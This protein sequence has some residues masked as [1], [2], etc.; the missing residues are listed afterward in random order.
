MTILLPNRSLTP[1]R[2]GFK[3]GAERVFEEGTVGVPDLYEAPLDQFGEDAVERRFTQK[4]M[5]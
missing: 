3:G 2:F 4:W 5:S 1:I